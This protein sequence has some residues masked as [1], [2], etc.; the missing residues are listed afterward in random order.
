[1][2]GSAV[3]ASL[4]SIG[5]YGL[6][7]IKHV[8]YPQRDL[9]VGPSPTPWIHFSSLLLLHEIT[10]SQGRTFEPADGR[11]D[12]RPD[13][14]FYVTWICFGSICSCYICLDWNE[15]AKA[16]PVAIIL[17]KF[18]F[19]IFLSRRLLINIRRML[20][21]LGSR[22]IEEVGGG[23]SETK[24]SEVGRF[25]QGRN[26]KCA[27]RDPRFCR[28]GEEEESFWAKPN[29]NWFEGLGVGR[30]GERAPMMSTGVRPQE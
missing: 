7:A 18:R 20:C 26:G 25:R 23:L 28:R 6:T 19:K 8:P 21:V 5:A 3:G 9:A 17:T 13:I 14:L 24:E 11:T 4:L 16:N 15:S 10:F 12:K 1:M 29:E 2:P 27:S 22:K 30:D